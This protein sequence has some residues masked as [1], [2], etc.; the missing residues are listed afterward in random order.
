[1]RAAD[2]AAV[3]GPHY[4]LLVLLLQLL[5][6]APLDAQLLQLVLNLGGE[7][8]LLQVGVA[9]TLHGHCARVDLELNLE[10]GDGGRY[11]LSIGGVG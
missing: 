10:P 3:K 11:R 5:L 7:R 6:E 8:G 2:W 4:L 9:A 1:L